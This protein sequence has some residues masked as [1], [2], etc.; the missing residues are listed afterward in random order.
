M[1][2]SACGCCLCRELE[3][4]VSTA[5]EQGPVAQG[6]CV[7]AAGARCCSGI[8]LELSR[9]DRDFSPPPYPLQPL[10]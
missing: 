8:G 1:L 9:Q 5:A 3:K 2:T 4:P 10:I 6:R 7:H